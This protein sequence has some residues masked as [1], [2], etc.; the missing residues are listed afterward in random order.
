MSKEQ[1]YNIS[2][3]QKAN[4][5]YTFKFYLY[6]ILSLIPAMIIITFIHEV[7]HI[8][9]ALIYGWD[10][11]EIHISIF[12][13]LLELDHSWVL[14]GYGMVESSSKLIIFALA[15]SLHT[16]IWG[17]LF[18][19]LYYKYDL[20]LFFEIFFYIYSFIMI[21]EMIAYIF[22]DLFYIKI[23][24]WNFIYQLNPI[25]VGIFLALGIINLVLFSRNF[26]KI[27]ES[28][29]LEIIEF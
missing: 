10:I 26:D 12:P 9:V 18:F 11:I 25:I 2:F 4:R 7:G 24:D 8:I 19:Y 13:F 22:I 16:L 27:R 17:Y 21:F 20:P 1:W 15:G 5:N 6:I 3:T 14:V 28:L 23:G 29:G